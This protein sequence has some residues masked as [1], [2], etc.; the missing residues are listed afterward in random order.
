[1]RVNLQ[2][3]PIF[4]TNLEFIF[5]Q[6]SVGA[7]V[8]LKLG[9]AEAFH[10]FVSHSPVRVNVANGNASTSVRSNLRFGATGTA[11]VGLCFCKYAS[12]L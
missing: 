12:C 8:L 5:I 11:S 3:Q 4:W 7:P 1:M 10:P 9:N 2:K 6:N